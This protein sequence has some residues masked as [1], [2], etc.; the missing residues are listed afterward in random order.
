MVTVKFFQKEEIADEKLK[1]SVIAAK[2]QGQWIFCRHKKR[3]T[4]EIPGGHR[5]SGEGTDETAKRELYEETGATEFELKEVCI[6]GVDGGDEMTYGALYFAEVTA[7]GMLP[8]EMEIGEIKLFD[9]LPDELTYPA[10][11]PYLF[12]HIQGWLNLQSNPNELWDI[13]NGNQ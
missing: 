9:H 2:Y 13:Y 11:Q 4:W 8:P 7:L 10:I 1:F 12:E 3:S 6:Y 5:E